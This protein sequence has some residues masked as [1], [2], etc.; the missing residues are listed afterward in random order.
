MVSHHMAKWFSHLLNASIQKNENDQLYLS[1]IKNIS[2]RIWANISL[3]WIDL[4]RT[5]LSG[6]RIFALCSVLS[7]HHQPH[8]NAKRIILWRVIIFL[9]LSALLSPSEWLS[10]GV[11]AC[12]MKHQLIKLLKRHLCNNGVYTSQKKGWVYNIVDDNGLL[13]PQTFTFFTNE[14]KEKKERNSTS[15]VSQVPND[16]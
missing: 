7:A 9:P 1:K 14:L 8:T 10:D 4:K 5:C 2:T 15:L 3:G 12:V 11:S 6:V 13:Q 16:K